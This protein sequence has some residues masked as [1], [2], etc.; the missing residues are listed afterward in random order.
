MNGWQTIR[1]E[2]LYLREIREDDAEIIVSWRSDPQVYQYFKNPHRITIEEHLNWYR[3]A[4]RGQSNMI[5]WICYFGSDPV[6]VFGI[7]KLFEN[8]A[9]VSYLIDPKYQHRGYAREVLDV[10][11][12]QAEK[13]WNITS[14]TADVHVN[15]MASVKFI[16][17]M[18]F[19]EDKT[20]G[21]FI[22]YCKK[23]KTGGRSSNE[24]DNW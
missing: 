3:E 16:K 7:K 12:R 9:E 19:M 13:K 15:N 5:Y 17:A 14:V 4:Y 10:I 1:T 2:R 18:G 6:G 20:D 11:L 8:S 21:F 24:S 22:T 23:I